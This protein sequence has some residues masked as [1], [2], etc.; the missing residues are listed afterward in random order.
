[1][2]H[3]DDEEVEKVKLRFLAALREAQSL[4]EACAVSGIEPELAEEW[5]ALDPDFAQRVEGVLRFKELATKLTLQ[6]QVGITDERMFQ[7]L[8]MPTEFS[9]PAMAV[10]LSHLRRRGLLEGE[11][12]PKKGRRKP[13]KGPKKGPDSE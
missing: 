2:Q 13:P 5:L 1:M 10:A 7:V 3:M 11:D 12:R 8:A 4:K 6:G 9:G